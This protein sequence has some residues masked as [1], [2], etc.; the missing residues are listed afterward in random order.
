MNAISIFKNEKFGAVR[1]VMQGNDPWFVGADIAQIL[2]HKESVK[3]TRL[4][5][6]DEKDIHKVETPGGIQE[7]SIISESG[8][9]TIL[10][11]SNKKIA[12][13]FQR[14]VTRE[15]LP[16]IRKNGAYVHASPD[17]A[18]EIIMARAILAAKSTID[19]LQAK[20]AEDAPK[21]E[22]HD[23]YLFSNDEEERTVNWLAKS[24]TQDG[25]RFSDKQ[26]FA[27]LRDR[28]YLQHQKG[29]NWNVPYQRYIDLGW[30]RVKETHVSIYSGS[31]WGRTTYVTKL[32]MVEL[33][34][35]IKKW[36]DR[37]LEVVT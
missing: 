4:L 33:P 19:T 23:A 29:G 31:R 3:I 22:L 30:F 6:D 9:Y 26:L 5:D 20:V 15:V 36:C 34:K 1:V 32:G 37:N 14:W 16:S 11:R 17:E 35:R 10:V 12:K 2:E 27:W 18:P 28:G 8:L 7:M 13:P 24:L 21:V 25:Y